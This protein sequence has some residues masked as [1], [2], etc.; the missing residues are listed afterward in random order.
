MI[1]SALGSASERFRGG[2]IA[3]HGARCAISPEK[4]TY[5]SIR[6]RDGR[7]SDISG[8]SSSRRASRSPTN[9]ELTGFLVLPGLINAHDHLEYSVFPRLGDPPY[10]NYVDW[11]EDIHNKFPDIIARYRAVPK[12]V[13][14]WFGG[15]RNLLC[16]VTTVSHH[17]PLWPELRR[18]DFP[19][20]VVRENGWGHSLALGSDLR[21]AR[22]ATPE[23]RAFVV[24]A[25]EGVDG[26]SR[27]ELAHLQN[28]GILDADTVLVHGLAID[29]DSLKQMIASQASLII[30]PTSNNFLYDTVPD[31]SVLSEI[32]QVAL[33]SDSPLTAEGDL[34]D[35]VRF[36]IRI[37]GI[38]PLK[39]FAMTTTIPAKILRLDNS[40]GTITKSGLADL[41]AVRDTGPTAIDRFQTLSAADIEFAMIGG[42]VQLASDAVLDRL[43]HP[44]R[45]G[46]EPLEVDG[47]TRWL[48]APISDLLRAAE[49][50][51]GTGGVRLGSRAVCKPAFVEE[52]YAV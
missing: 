8:S 34:L 25:C 36:A 10:R 11:G 28:L 20:R 26:R 12:D 37:C 46:L 16:G 19:L 30:C 18:N 22:A 4:T 48:R 23:G 41:I 9:V 42:R 17:N 13:R 44:M 49:D 47:A 3:I 5:A 31:L 14:L 40:A 35:E 32:K 21:V 2:T 51:L 24:H 15:I 50:V 7:I 33:G 38:S 52:K 29:R 45:K 6:I 43:P 39:A 27:E 1:M